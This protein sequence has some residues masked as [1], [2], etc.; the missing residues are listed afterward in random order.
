VLA[1]LVLATLAW[2]G[3]SLLGEQQTTSPPEQ[4][5]KI[6]VPDLVDMTIDEAEAEIG[7]DLDL[8]ISD[9]VDGER[10]VDTILSQDP[11][12]GEL[13]KGSTILVTVVGTQVADVPDVVGASRAAAEQA[14]RGT[15]FEVGVEEQESSFE[16][17]G[18]VVS[19]DPGGGTRV[20]AGSEVTITV[21]T[22]PSAVEVPDVTGNTPAQAEAILQEAGLELGPQSED[23]SDEV[24]EGSI[25]YQD[26]AGG[27]SVEPGSA[28]GVTVSLGPE[29]VEVPEVYG[30]TLTEAQQL[31]DDAGLNSTVFEVE[32]E[33]AAG[34]ALSTDPLAGTLLDPETTVTIYYSA[35]PP[36]VTASPEPTAQPEASPETQQEQPAQENSG[37]GGGNEEKAKEARE[38]R[39]EAREDRKDKKSDRREARNDE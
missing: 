2:A 19:Q 30:A 27:E 34:T 20:E 35:G 4:V 33:E 39:R 6:A 9:T 37:P 3:Y 38:N 24:A 10:P 36:E 8:E 31:V 22:G 12:G 5:P 16:D 17:E 15:G 7:D 18:L 25:F 1:L 29:Q 21:G 13:E 32:G 23:Y 11:S 26:P 14:L 28:V